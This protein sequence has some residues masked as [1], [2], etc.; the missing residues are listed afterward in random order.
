[1]A[2]AR[3]KGSFRNSKQRQ[4]EG[5]F[6][7]FIVRNYTVNAGSENSNTANPETILIKG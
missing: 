1:M 7:T 3:R 4:I 6:F 5:H 2:A